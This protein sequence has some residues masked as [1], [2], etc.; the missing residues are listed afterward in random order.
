MISYNCT[1]LNT[2]CTLLTPK[3]IICKPYLFLQLHTPIVNCLPKSVS[4]WM[5]NKY[6][7]LDLCK[8]KFIVFFSKPTSLTDLPNSING[9]FTVFAWTQILKI[10][11]P[12]VFA[13]I[14]H[15][16]CQKKFFALSLKFI[17]IIPLLDTS[18]A[19]S[20]IQATIVFSLDDCVSL[21][22][23]VLD[24]TLDPHLVYPTEQPEWSC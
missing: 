5:M 16:I 17:Q 7:R 2:I 1:A 24:S 3:C 9:S 13:Y 11:Y 22:T 4:M 23:D 6:V 20:L 18:V 15:L 21:L 12:S 14:P 10:H 8:I 19:T